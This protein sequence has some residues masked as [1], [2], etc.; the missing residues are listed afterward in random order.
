[1]K[2]LIGR[3]GKLWQQIDMH[4]VNCVLIDDMNKL[5]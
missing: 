5:S 3:L 4:V 2:H 1:M